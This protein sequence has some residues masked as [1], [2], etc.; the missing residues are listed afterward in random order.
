MPVED[1]PGAGVYTTV[2]L[3]RGEPEV[4]DTAPPSDSDLETFI[5]RAED[6]IDEWLG[7]YALHTTGASA[8]RKIAQADIASW[9]W[10][11]LQR[12]ATR[13]AVRLY[14]AG[15]VLEEPEW[16]EISGPRFRKKGYRGAARAKLPDVIAPLRASGLIARTARARP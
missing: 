10:A 5:T 11:K 13:L 12:A 4:P 14:V 8:G 2:T 3:M 1:L 6:Q 16:D 15:D 9:R 7:P